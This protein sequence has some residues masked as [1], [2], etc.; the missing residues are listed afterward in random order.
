LGQ[1]YRDLEVIVVDDGSTDNTR[2]VITVQY[3]NEPRVNYSYQSNGGVAAARNHGIRVARGE[4]IA[5]LDSDDTWK[6][7]KISLQVKV[8]QD[9]LDIGMV[10]TDMEAISQDGQVIAERFLRKMYAAYQQYPDGAVLFPERFLLSGMADESAGIGASVKVCIGDIFLPMMI[11]NLVHTSTVLMRRERLAQVGFFPE[12]FRHGGEDYDFHLRTT[13][14]GPVGFVDVSSIYYRVGCLDQI[15]VKDSNIFFATA[16]L[17][18]IRPYWQSYGDRGRLPKVA[19][20]ILKARAYGWIG[21][22]LFGRGKRKAARRFLAQSVHYQL[23]QAR[24]LIMLIR[25]V[26][27]PKV[28]TFFLKGYQA[29]K[30]AVK[31]EQSKSADREAKVGPDTRGGST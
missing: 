24:T 23:W 14:A 17:R 10:W 19:L 30:G 2:D 20:G 7:W 16:Y 18:T 9:R 25:T 21:M 26:L 1:T 4:F 28:D 11:G 13:Y 15:T 29:L 8:L 12:M 5:L 3:A 27:P 22:A 6:P 31:L